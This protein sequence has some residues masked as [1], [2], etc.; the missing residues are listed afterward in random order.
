MAAVRGQM[1][2]PTFSGVTNSDHIVASPPRMSFCC[3]GVS[4]AVAPSNGST[5]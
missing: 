3:S 4:L 5:A 1:R 2:L